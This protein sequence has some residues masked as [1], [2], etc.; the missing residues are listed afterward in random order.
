MTGS[1][2]LSVALLQQIELMLAHQRL[3][4]TNGVVVEDI[5]PFEFQAKNNYP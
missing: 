4:M 3:Q 2:N 5:V 1:C